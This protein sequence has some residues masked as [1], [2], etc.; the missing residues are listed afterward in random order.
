MRGIWKSMLAGI[1]LAVLFGMPGL[2]KCSYA[3]TD[4]TDKVEIIKSRMMFDR[5]T[6]QNYL[7]VSVKNISED[8]LLTPI[9]VVVDSISSTDVTVVNADG[10]TTDGKPYFIYDTENNNL[11]PGAS[12]QSKALRFSNPNRLRFTYSFSV[13]SAGIGSGVVEQSPNAKV[14]N[15]DVLDAKL[16]YADVNFSYFLFDADILNQ[17]S[18]LVG[19]ILIFNAS[20]LTPKGA[21]RKIENLKLENGLLRVATS[22]AAITDAIKNCDIQIS[23]TLTPGRVNSARLHDGVIFTHNSPFTLTFEDGISKSIVLYDLDGNHDTKDDQVRVDGAITFED[24]I[25]LNMVIEDFELQELKFTNETGESVNLDLF[26]GSALSYDKETTLAE[27]DLGTFTVW[28]GWFPVVITPELEVLIGS[29]GE[30]QASLSTGFEQEASVTAGLEYKNDSW[31]PIFEFEN[32]YGY[33]EPVLSAG[34]FATAYIQPNVNVLLYAVAGPYAGLKGHVD[35]E[36]DLLTQPWWVLYAGLK[37]PVGV[38]GEIIDFDLAN[39]EF[40]DILEFLR[41]QSDESLCKPWRYYLAQATLDCPDVDFYDSNQAL[42]FTGIGSGC[43]HNAPG[44]GPWT[45]NCEEGTITGWISLGSILHDQCCVDNPSEGIM[46]DGDFN[47][48]DPRLSDRPCYKEWWEASYD[49]LFEV[50][51]Q[52]DFNPDYPVGEYY[53]KENYTR[54]APY[55][56]KIPINDIDSEYYAGKPEDY[57]MSGEFEKDDNGNPIEYSWLGK[58]YCKCSKPDDQDVDGVPDDIDNCPNTYNP[59]QADSDGDGIGDVCEASGSNVSIIDTFDGS[60]IDTTIWKRNSTHYEDIIGASTSVHDGYLD[61]REDATDN[62]GQVVTRFDPQEKITIRLVHNMH[63]GNAYFYPSISLES[64]VRE[65]IV[66]LDWQ[67]TDYARN[68]CYDSDNYNKVR[69]KKDS[70]Y[71]CSD[72]VYSNLTSSSFYDRWSTAVIEYDMITGIVQADLDDN[73]TI[74]IQVVLPIEERKPVTGVELNGYGWYTG[75]WHRIDEISI[76]GIGV[77]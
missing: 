13:E 25:Y 74:D 55:N 72:H 50:Q 66:E 61:I 56:A 20:D 34:G 33:T 45:P 28:F 9:K 44:A 58:K 60:T 12:T 70:A 71:S 8:V 57:C 6:S 69:L 11:M 27:F 4:V 49:N 63:P 30:I 35:L 41:C 23:L 29:N 24:T 73:G 19:D 15:K 62:G 2:V 21:L 54:I 39:K 65:K 31:S 10:T 26:V 52:A 7:D 40:G 3:E 14:L 53:N 67:K 75:H 37:A 1:M 48:L 59:D 38:V 51:W 47:D 22:Q 46:C 36:A 68:Y 32:E 17:V 43:S 18:L 16:Q 42:C 77:Q 64:D 5:S 76:E